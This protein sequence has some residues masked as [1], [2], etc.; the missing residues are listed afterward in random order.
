MPTH[1]RHTYIPTSTYNAHTHIQ[2]TYIDIHIFLHTSHA[3]TRTQVPTPVYACSHAHTQG[4]YVHTS[5]H[6]HIRRHAHTGT[7]HP[8]T[9]LGLWMSR[10]SCFQDLFSKRRT[11]LPTRGGARDVQVTPL[12][13]LCF[14]F[15][16]H[17]GFQ[18]FFLTKVPHPCCWARRRPGCRQRPQWP[19]VRVPGPAC[20]GPRAPHP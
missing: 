12:L 19:S 17:S 9:A 13:S 2:C 10:K 15:V 5:K 20:S 8:S 16:L 11:V 3:H 1:S 6:E 14:S 7:T 4:T 18:T